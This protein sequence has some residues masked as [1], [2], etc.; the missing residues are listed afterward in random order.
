MPTTTKIPKAL[1]AGEELFS[2]HCRV[3][4]LAPLREYKFHPDRKWKFD[5]Y[6]P[7]A[8]LAVEIEGGTWVKGRHNSGA[9]FERDAQ[10]YNQAVLMGIFVLRYTTGMVERGD[11]LEDLKAF[12]KLPEVVG[13]YDLDSR[14]EAF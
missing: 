10:K 3:L 6:F 2:L 12:L 14:T 1:S 9:G 8:K 13:N 11:A 5:F 7:D 4:G